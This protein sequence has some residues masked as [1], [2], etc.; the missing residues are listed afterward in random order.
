MIKRKTSKKSTKPNK[1]RIVL[2]GA[3]ASFGSGHVYP[4]PTPLGNKLYDELK[5][6][7]PTSWGKL[8]QA[9]KKKFQDGFESGMQEI[10]DKYSPNIPLLMRHMT[11]YLAQFR[12]S[13]EDNLYTQLIGRIK[14]NDEKFYLLS[15]LNYDLLLELAISQKNR[16]VNYFSNKF[17]PRTISVWKLHGSCNFIPKNIQATRGISYTAGVVFDTPPVYANP[18]EA[19]QFCLSNTALYPAMCL[20]MEAKPSQISQ[21]FIRKKQQEWKKHIEN[22]ER[23]LIIG[24]YPYLDYTHIWDSLTKTNA[25]IG[26]VGSKDG[27][28]NWIKKSKRSL[29]KTKF[30]GSRWNQVFDKSI[31]FLVM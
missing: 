10:W 30:I 31:K 9:V 7:Y 8:P 29:S 26:Y 5:R 21:Q 20:Y 1:P 12:P 3:G 14:D 4:E 22:A 19:I 28:D 6:C 17:E 23:I 15:S 27:F 25:K 13:S 18:N 11:L 2:F 16:I 24:V